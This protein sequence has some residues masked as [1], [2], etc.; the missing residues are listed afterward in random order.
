LKLT[1]QK[2]L[3]ILRAFSYRNYRLYFLGQGISQIGNW[4]TLLA[5]SW[6]V[7]QLTDSAFWLG[8]VG[9]ADRI[10]ALFIS[11]I[12]G[13]IADRAAYTHSS[14]SPS[15]NR[16]LRQRILIITQILSMVQSLLLA[17]LALTGIINIWQ[18]IA[19]GL[20][21][22]IV[23]ALYMPTLQAFVNEIIERPEDLGN[24]IALNSSLVSSARLIGP[25]VAGFLV[26][27]VGAGIC[28]LLDGISYLAVITAFVM[29]KITPTQIAASTT[30]TIQ[31]LQEG[32]NYA[33]G[34]SA[35]RSML[36]L[37]SLLGFVGLPYVILTPIYAADILQGG[38]ETLGMLMT[39][40]ALG[41][42]IASV[43]LSSKSNIFGLEKAI[44][45]APALLGSGLI[46][47]S[48]S[49]VLW[50][51]LPVMMLIGFSVIL[52]LAATNTVLQTIVENDKIGR[53]MSFSSMAFLGI[54]PFG[55][56]FSGWLASQIGVTNAFLLNGLACLGGALIFVQQ[57]KTIRRITL[58]QE[59]Q[60]GGVDLGTSSRPRDSA[61]F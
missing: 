50:L 5:T 26:A 25:A 4:S 28:F 9:F 1:I 35:M 36:L 58:F 42:L 14:A 47:F 18:I 27:S 40:S 6:L 43:Y 19:L 7:Y 32:F 52:Q 33:F 55:N 53:I 22:G 39:A 2:K 17:V 48:Q 54:V 59:T 21:Q 60:A 12:G 38:S 3:S 20:F 56:L 61:F 11:P 16:G 31:K 30:S 8:V 41:A 46:I 23:N 51:S 49:R 13:V 37:L 24:A 34:N 10:P 29:M 45:L 15:G 44:A 57:L